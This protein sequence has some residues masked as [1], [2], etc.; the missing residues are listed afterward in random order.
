M[1]N[2]AITLT[3]RD[4]QQVHFTCETEQNLLVAAEQEGIVLPSL[5]RDG[6]CGACL[7]IC[8]EG[9]YRLGSY[10]PQALPPDAAAR[11]DLLLCR[12]HPQS[13]LSL[14]APYDF[15]R[16]RFEVL[17]GRAAEIID[18]MPIAERT[19]RLMLRLQPDSSGGQAAEFEPGQYM[20]LE[21]PNLGISRAYSIANTP[22]W[23][24]EL[25]F[26]I[27]LQPGGRFST[28]LEREAKIGQRIDVCGPSGHFV[29]QAQS[30]RPRY[31]VGGGTGLA[32]MLSMLRHMAEL[33]EPQPVH[34]YFGV[35]HEA[36]LF[37]LDELRSLTQIL[38][39][40]KI[41]LCVWRAGASWDGFHGT[42]VQ[43]LQRDLEQGGPAPDL[44]LCGPP[45]LIDAA[46][47]TARSFGIADGHIFS[48]RFLPST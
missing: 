12:A 29:L 18:L 23:T 35:N 42:P 6:G 40:L 14:E 16:I 11:G 24:G 21:I 22:N 45:A 28:Y 27:R 43:A 39:H 38:P 19:I 3:T 25:E 8:V 34:L 33:E 31:F 13:D 5:C 2:H 32:P 30:L 9:D 17:A 37:Y 48:E 47:E 4:G 1:T 7:C 26:L 44:Y 20:S 15:D 36:E 41:D 10:N 46:T